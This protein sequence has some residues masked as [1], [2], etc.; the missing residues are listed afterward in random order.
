MATL[1]IKSCFRVGGRFGGW[2][3][4]SQPLFPFLAYLLLDHPLLL[5]QLP[6]TLFS[7]A[8]DLQSGSWGG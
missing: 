4:T 2:T 6:G 5:L 7:Q 3:L 1:G 8:F